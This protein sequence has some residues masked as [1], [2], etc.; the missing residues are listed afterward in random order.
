MSSTPPKSFNPWPVGIVAFFVCFITVTVGLI[1]F[2]SSQGMDLVTPDYYEQEV[3]Y[4]SQHERI[5]RTQTLT[6]QISVS[7]DA[8]TQRILI[9]L[10]ASHAQQSCRGDIQ[11]YRPSDAGL[12]RHIKL[13]MGAQGTQALD[14]RGLQPGLWKVRVTWKSG[15]Q[16]FF[17][18]Q[19]VVV[20]PRPS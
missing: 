9:T 8:S 10:P 18:D 12:D 19:S 20:P 15:G 4:Q 17:T 3:R 5:D 1:V 14:A 2:L 7:H 11:L 16:E 13:D 6:K